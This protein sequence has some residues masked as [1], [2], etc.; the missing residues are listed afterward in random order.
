MS[1]SKTNRD[2]LLQHIR[3]LHEV[4]LRLHLLE[5]FLRLSRG[6]LGRRWYLPQLLVRLL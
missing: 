4:L 3:E 1:G 2:L 5:V 6:C